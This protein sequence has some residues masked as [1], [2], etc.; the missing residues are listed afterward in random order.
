MSVLLKS[1]EDFRD[2]HRDV[3]VIHLTNSFWVFN[4]TLRA[5]SFGIFPKDVLVAVRDPCVYTNNRLKLG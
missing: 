4:P 5:E 3:V 2:T 1:I